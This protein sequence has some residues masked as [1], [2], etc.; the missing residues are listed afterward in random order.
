MASISFVTG[1]ATVTTVVGATATILCNIRIYPVWDG[2]SSNG[3]V[4][5]NFEGSSAFLQ[6]ILG[7]KA[8]R[9]SWGNNQG[10]LIISN[11]TKNEDEGQ[12]T[13]TSTYPSEQKT[14]KLVVRGI[15]FLL[16]HLNT[17]LIAY[18]YNI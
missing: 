10:D 2:P 11:V 15:S 17:I 3:S 7:D 13:C 16:T 8:A 9:L 4:F 18:M 14:I 5:Y 1:Q 12:Y 6:Q